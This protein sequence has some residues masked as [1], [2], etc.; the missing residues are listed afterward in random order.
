MLNWLLVIVAI[1]AILSYLIASGF[2]KDK[3]Q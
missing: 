1:I 3:Y 2:I